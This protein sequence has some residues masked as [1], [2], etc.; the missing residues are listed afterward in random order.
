LARVSASDPCAV[1]D[2]LG[3]QPW[4]CPERSSPTAIQSCGAECIVERETARDMIARY[5]P[6]TKRITVGADK[7]FD[8]AGFLSGM[9]DFNVTPHLAQKRPLVWSLAG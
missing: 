9:R 4:Q 5:S 3:V 7:G 2:C 1:Y 8:T 6:G